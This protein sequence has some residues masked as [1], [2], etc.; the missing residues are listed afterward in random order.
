MATY[1]ALYDTNIDTIAHEFH[2]LGA[3]TR[4]QW[5]YDGETWNSVT[6]TSLAAITDQAFGNNVNVMTAVT[7]NTA[8]MIYTTITPQSIPVARTAAATGLANI[9]WQGIAFGNNTWCAVG[10]GLDTTK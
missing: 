5:S 2:C 7:A 10:G 3:A 6:L 9:G 1:T 4:S 8:N